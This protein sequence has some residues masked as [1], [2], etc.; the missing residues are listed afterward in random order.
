[1]VSPD[2]KN[3]LSTPV[4]TTARFSQSGPPT[5]IGGRTADQPLA[6]I[7]AEAEVQTVGSDEIARDYRAMAPEERKATAQLLKNA[8]WRV[9][10]TGKYNTRV[11]DALLQAY[12]GFTAEVQKLSATDPYFFQNNE[13]DIKKYLR[14]TRIRGEGAGGPQVYRTQYDPTDEVLARGINEV[15]EDLIGRGA[16]KEEIQKY[17]KKIR[18]QLSKVENMAQ[19]TVTDM[20]GGVQQRTERPGFDANAFLYEQLGG[21]DEAK[22]RQIFS[23]YD[24]FKRTIGVQ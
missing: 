20:G 13:Y 4:I 9:P 1:M 21:T 17:S 15:Y 7:S 12:D 3:S 24:A 10:V 23:F 11:R 5:V 19:T 22:T 14:D 2:Y 6:P 18:K 16:S 8:G